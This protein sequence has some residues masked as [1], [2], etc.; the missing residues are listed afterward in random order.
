[1]KKL[2]L[3]NAQLNKKGRSILLL[4][5]FVLV[6]G[7]DADLSRYGRVTLHNTLNKDSFIF[8]VEDEFLQKKASSKQDKK[9]PKM[10]KAEVKLLK[11]L[12]HQKSYCLNDFGLP[13]FM[14][15]SRQQKVYDITYAHLIEKNYNI[16]SVAPRMYFGQCVRK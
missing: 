1:M 8:S 14:I 12:L 3:L 5:F 6:M 4:P 11:V 9:H 16:Q 13:E 10:T 15:T 2:N 7:C